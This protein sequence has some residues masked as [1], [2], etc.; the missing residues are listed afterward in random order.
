MRLYLSRSSIV[1]MFCV[2]GSIKFATL[3]WLS[4]VDHGKVY[5]YV[6]E[7]FCCNWVFRWGFGFSCF[8]V[9]GKSCKKIWAWKMKMLSSYFYQMRFHEHQHF[10]MLYLH[11]FRPASFFLFP[12]PTSNKKT[13]KGPSDPT[14]PQRE[15]LTMLGQT[16]HA[17]LFLVL[18][19]LPLTSHLSPADRN[20]KRGCWDRNRTAPLDRRLQECSST[21]SLFTATRLVGGFSLV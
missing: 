13:S 4:E 14:H 6:W 1:L 16:K 5:E 20:L 8:F 18:L 19:S 17:L 21:S 2:Q 11:T 9:S 10:R 15:H 7:S 3:L 12:K